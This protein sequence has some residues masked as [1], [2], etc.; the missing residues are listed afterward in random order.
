MGAIVLARATN[1]EP[2]VQALA[3]NGVDSPLGEVV[4]GSALIG[5]GTNV[6]CGC[7]SGHGVMGVPRGSMR[8]IVATGTFMV[9]GVLAATYLHPMIF[10]DTAPGEG[11]SA[12]VPSVSNVINLGLG[13][14]AAYSLVKDIAQHPRAAL[15]TFACGLTFGIGLLISGMM[16]AEKIRG[17]LDISP[18]IDSQSTK[19]WDPSM[20]I[21]MA[22][23]VLT[24]MLTFNLWLIPHG[25]LK[26]HGQ[27]A[28]IENHHYSLPR[29]TAIT[30]SLIIGAA[31]FGVGWGLSGICVGPAI[32]NAAKGGITSIVSLV[33]IVA[34]SVLA[35]YVPIG[36]AH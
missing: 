20:I 32:A 36:E 8:S 30:S 5:F 1:F 13:A 25:T 31:I 27:P 16:N 28:A 7:T 6:G 14:F 21:V 10:A 33:S 23:A 29:K 34:G 15:T 2:L 26:H 17:F 22:T 19:S 18:L 4:L 24:N 3:A 35:D 9:T 12:I 11:V